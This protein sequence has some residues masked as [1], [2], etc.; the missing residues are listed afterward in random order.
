MSE[1]A[2]VIQCPCGATLHGADDDEVVT[3][4]QTHAR[5]THDQEL[6]RDQA[7]SM[8]RPAD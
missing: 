6:S 1:T 2:K 4:A 5:D 7:L 3:A 8:A